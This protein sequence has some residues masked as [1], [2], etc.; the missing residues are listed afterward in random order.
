MPVL[1]IRGWHDTAPKR[2]S[3]L[4]RVRLNPVQ[5]RLPDQR[6]GFIGQDDFNMC[7]IKQ[8][9]LRWQKRDNIVRD[10]CA[11]QQARRVAGHLAHSARGANIQDGHFDL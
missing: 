10:I 4:I 2:L 5:Q 7:K 9:L 8:H 3:L 6:H 11:G 1:E